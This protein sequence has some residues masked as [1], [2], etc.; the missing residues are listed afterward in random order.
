MRTTRAG[1]TALALATAMAMTGCAEISGGS[2]GAGGDGVEFGATKEEYQAAFEG[3]GPITL[4]AQTLAPKGSVS[5]KPT[6]DYLAAVTEWSGGKIIFDISYSNAIAP[7]NETAEAFVDGRLDV[8]NVIPVYKPAE[9][10]AY[11]AV[12]NS[13]GAVASPG[14]A[15]GNLQANSAPI[16]LAFSTPEIEAEFRNAGVVPLAPYFVTGPPAMVCKDKRVSLNDVKGAQISVSSAAQREQVERLGATAVSLSFAEVFEGLQRGVI[17]CTVTSL[18]AIQTG[19]LLQVAKYIVLDEQVGFSPASAAFGF[20]VSRWDSLPLVARQLLRDRVDVFLESSIENM[21]WPDASNLVGEIEKFGGTVAS[22][23][24]DAR[25]KLA[26]IKADQLDAL[27]ENTALADP[28][29]AIEGARKMSEAWLARSA[30]LTGAED[31]ALT[32]FKEWFARREF[33]IRPWVDAVME[34]IYL[35]HRPH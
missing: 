3:V 18:T 16:E 34:D 15:V 26:G 13:A 14:L 8:A 23:S 7:P 25:D 6:E 9:Y 11:N 28:R 17:D 2:S 27:S 5:G 31:V 35:P 4:T 19:G 21:N 29:A 10:P 20:S 24:D 1:F 33:E 32:D 22:W 30:E 12:I